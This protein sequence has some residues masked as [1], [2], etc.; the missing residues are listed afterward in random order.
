MRFS[1]ISSKILALFLLALS[2]PASAQFVK[3]V[4]I[5]AELN[6]L[7][8]ACVAYAEVG[9]TQ[10]PDF[11]RY[12]Y[13]LAKLGYGTTYDTRISLNG[14]D[15]DVEKLKKG[16]GIGAGLRW[17]PKRGDQCT[18]SIAVRLEQD[19]NLAKAIEAKVEKILL[20][21]GYK[22]QPLA[23]GGTQLSTRF[24]KGANSLTILG[25]LNYSGKTRNTSAIWFDISNE[26]KAARK[27]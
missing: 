3:S 7:V 19:F 17:Q 27:N 22:K 12:G 21:L 5:D 25:K 6:R 13:D 15:V 9:Q 16:T 20:K 4:S 1:K 14:R 10:M 24:T 11:A 18:V 8:R 26:N 23:G 2:S